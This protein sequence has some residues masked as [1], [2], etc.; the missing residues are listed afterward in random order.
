MESLLNKTSWS[1]ACSSPG[2][3]IYMESRSFNTLQECFDDLHLIQQVIL[4]EE[5]QAL[6]VEE[7]LKRVLSFYRQF[8]PYR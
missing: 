8:V 2:S 1:Q 3:A 4:T 5:G 7:V 6:S